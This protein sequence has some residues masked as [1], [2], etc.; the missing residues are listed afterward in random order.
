MPCPYDASC[1][2]TINKLN[3]L[4]EAFEYPLAVIYQPRADL[5]AMRYGDDS[6]AA[7]PGVDYLHRGADT[8]AGV[9]HQQHIAGVDIA[10]VLFDYLGDMVIGSAT[11]VADHRVEQLMAGEP[12]DCLFTPEFAFIIPGLK[13]RAGQIDFH[14]R[15]FLS[16]CGWCTSSS[17]SILHVAGWRMRTYANH[18]S[19][20]DDT[21][22][23]RVWQGECDVI[24]RV[25]AYRIRP[26]SV[27]L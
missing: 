22:S 16:C 19:Y 20:D 1:T 14:A 26:K 23:A 17:A 21:M 6:F 18:G 12:G 4:I 10:L 15:W 3:R 24:G 25:G 9:I 7:L 5:P 2:I 13:Y 27:E 11:V 8:G